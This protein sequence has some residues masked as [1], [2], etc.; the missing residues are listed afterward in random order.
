MKYV[1]LRLEKDLDDIDPRKI[2]ISIGWT[3]SGRGFGVMH[4]DDVLNYANVKGVIPVL[5]GGKTEQAIEANLEYPG[6]D[7]T[8]A[9]LPEPNDVYEP[10]P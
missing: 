9:S 7:G 2:A 5:T 8:Y 6:D 1:I 3:P 10:E 4:R